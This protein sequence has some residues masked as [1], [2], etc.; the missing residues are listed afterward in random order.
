[1]K[2]NDLFDELDHIDIV[3]THYCNMKCKQ[4]IDKFR[5][6][7][8]STLVSLDDIS[9]F[10]GIIRLGTGK[11]LEVLLLGGEPLSAPISYLKDVTEVIRDKGFIPIVSTNGLYKDKIIELISHFEWVQI[12]VHSDS[13]IEYWKRYKDKI[14]IKLSGDRSLT[15][16]K[17]NWFIESTKEYKR[18]SVS[19]YF[20]PDFKE[21]CTDN[22]VWKLLDTLDWKRNGS[23][24]YSFYNGV[25][26]KRC[27]PGE[28]NV[29]DEPSV[30]KLYPNGNYNKTWNNEEMNDYL[31]IEV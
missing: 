15:M 23:Y 27:I 25:R 31:K 10:L 11:K 24:M 17:L 16:N 20:T 3:I 12:T 19:M 1:M 21:L 29:I 18:R 26:F 28:T 14:N 6:S 8:E 4:C 22:E 2:N 13:E 9:K 5:S 30:P 7:A